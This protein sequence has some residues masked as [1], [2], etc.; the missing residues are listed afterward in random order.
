MNNNT[1]QQQQ[2][3]FGIIG[4]FTRSFDHYHND[5][6]RIHLISSICL[7][8]EKELFT[9]IN[10]IKNKEIYLYEI[11]YVFVISPSSINMLAQNKQPIIINNMVIVELTINELLSHLVFTNK[12]NEIFESIFGDLN[13]KNKDFEVLSSQSIFIFLNQMW[14]N[15]LLNFKIH[16]VDISGGSNPKRHILQTVDFGLI[17]GLIKL[18]KDDKIINKIIYESYLD[19]ILSSSIPLNYWAC[20][21]SQIIDGTRSQNLFNINYKIINELVSAKRDIESSS[22]FFGGILDSKN[23]DFNDI[24]VVNLKTSMDMLISDITLVMKNDIAKYELIKNNISLEIN[25][26][27]N[28]KSQMLNIENVKTRHLSNKAKKIFKK[29]KTAV[30]QERNSGGIIK[31]E[32]QISQC[33]FKLLNINN[34]ITEIQNELTKFLDNKDKYTLSVLNTLHTKYV[35]WFDRPI[36]KVKLISREH[37]QKQKINSYKVIRQ[38]KTLNQRHYSTL[39]SINNVNFKLDSPIYM[40]LQRIINNSPLN[41]KTQLKIEQ[42]LTD[43]GSIL[44]KSRIDKISDINYYKLNPYILKYLHKSIG[45]LEKLITSYR[46]NILERDR[47]L[48]QIVNKDQNEIVE[49]ELIFGLTNEIIISQL[50]GRLL[51]NY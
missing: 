33:N 45:E 21:R 51:R 40:E 41:F 6:D 48:A 43:Q 39:N 36:N 8:K 15:I 29:E 24:I 32:T 50:L 13:L 30:L 3:H 10:L 46:F 35:R 11:M 28:E 49:K 2:Q 42:F 37:K 31:L 4:K 9:L 47:M 26:L 12:K 1:Q 16:K 5:S 38:Y 44:L 17:N 18:F 14:S 19:P 23:K 20:A 34:K 22:G 7:L 25:K 27:L